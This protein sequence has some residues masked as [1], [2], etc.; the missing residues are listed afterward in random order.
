MKRENSLNRGKDGVLRFGNTNINDP[1][2]NEST[3]DDGVRTP[4]VVRVIRTL[5][6]RGPATAQTSMLQTGT[7]A[8]MPKGLSLRMVA[9]FIDHPILAMSTKV[10]NNWRASWNTQR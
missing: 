7:S 10:L 1:R 6:P 4:R 3:H 8:T 9:F 2:P 5:R